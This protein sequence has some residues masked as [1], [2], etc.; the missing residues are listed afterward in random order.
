MTA[1]ARPN[2]HISIGLRV[3]QHWCKRGFHLLDP[4]TERE[5]NT[6]SRRLSNGFVR[7]E[8]ANPQITPIL[9]SSAKTCAIR[10]KIKIVVGF[11]RGAR[12]VS[13]TMSEQLRMVK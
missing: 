6:I 10:R 8:F 9:I 4:Q 12:L 1:A 3:L 5:R 7:R 11:A 13:Q 2:G